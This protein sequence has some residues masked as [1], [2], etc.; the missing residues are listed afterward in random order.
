MSQAARE[1]LLVDDEGTLL[2][3]MSVYLR[4]LGFAV[5]TANTVAKAWEHVKRTPDQFAAMVLDA[6][7]AEDGVDNLVLQLLDA[8]P[9]LRVVVNSGYPVDMSVLERTAPGRVEFLH[10]P[11]SPDMLVAA[12]R[13]MLGPQEEV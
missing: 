3:L 8:H 4:R 12:V 7:M 1:L 5:T 6:G 11:F 10:K 2:K 13:R 9:R